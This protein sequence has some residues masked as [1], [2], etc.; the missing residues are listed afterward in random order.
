MCNLTYN[1]FV[2]VTSAFTSKFYCKIWN[3]PWTAKLNKIYGTMAS[4][5]IYVLYRIWWKTK[6]LL[7]LSVWRVIFPHQACDISI[8][9][10]F[11]YNSL[12]NFQNPK[13]IES[14]AM[15]T[16]CLEAAS[17]FYLTLLQEICT[18]FDLDLSCRRFVVYC[19]PIFLWLSEIKATFFWLVLFV[20]RR[21]SVYGISDN[22]HA[23][24]LRHLPPNK[25]SSSYICQHC[26]VHLGDIAR[27]RNQNRQAESFYR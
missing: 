18:A 19:W 15:L 11:V 20:V 4:K 13:R 7:F 22:F 10:S 12:S 17:G 2:C 1:W 5:T 16:W 9:Y 25:T 21:D 3:M 27:Y 6:R 8:Q 14:Q 23:A 24:S 26:L